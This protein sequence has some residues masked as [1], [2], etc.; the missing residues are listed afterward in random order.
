MFELSLPIQL[1]SIKFDGKKR[2][3]IARKIYN[4]G[5]TTREKRK[6]KTDT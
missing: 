1:Y 5:R 3:E 6:Q 2:Q 4:N